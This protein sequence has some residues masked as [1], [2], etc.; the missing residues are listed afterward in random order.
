MHADVMVLAGAVDDVDRLAQKV[1]TLLSGSV[2]LLMVVAAVVVTW[3][4]SKSVVAA[5]VAALGGAALWFVVLNAPMFRDSVGDDLTPSSSSSS[6][7]HGA[8]PESAVV[9]SYAPSPDRG[10]QR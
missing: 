4:K 3:A 7:V 5:F 2:M 6:A 1:T 8:G 10:E 9:Q